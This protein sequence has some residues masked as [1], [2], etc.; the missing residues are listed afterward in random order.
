ML[1]TLLRYDSIGELYPM[2]ASS[3]NKSFLT[4][5]ATSWHPMTL[6][7]GMRASV[8]WVM[9]SF[10]ASWK[11]LTFPIPNLTTTHALP[12]TLPSTCSCCF[13]VPQIFLC[14]LFNCYI[15]MYGL[16]PL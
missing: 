13:L 15:V 2:R 11:P 4:L 6:R 7:C 8:T 5:T 3:T 16:L 10:T 1:T 12:V 9:V 14:F